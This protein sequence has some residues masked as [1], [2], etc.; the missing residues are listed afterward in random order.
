MS[1][2][3]YQ[4]YTLNNDA[5]ERDYLAV[6][7]GNQLEC[8]WICDTYI[9]EYTI[10]SNANVNTTIT[11]DSATDP[12][13]Q[14]TSDST[15]D[16]TSTTSTINTSTTSDHEATQ[17]SIQSNPYILSS[18]PSPVPIL[19][20]T[21]E[22]VRCIYLPEGCLVRIYYSWTR[23]IWAMSSDSCWN[24]RCQDDGPYSDLV[25]EFESRIKESFDSYTC[26]LDKYSVYFWH[27][28]YTNDDGTCTLNQDHSQFYNPCSLIG[29]RVF[30]P[31]TKQYNF[32]EYRCPIID[33]TW[34]GIYTYLSHDTT[35]LPTTYGVLTIEPMRFITTKHF[36]HIRT[37]RGEYNMLYRYLQLRPDEATLK[38]FIYYYASWIPEFD[39]VE[40]IITD[41]ITNMILINKCSNKSMCSQDIVTLL[42]II[43]SPILASIILGNQQVV[44]LPDCAF[45]YKS[46]IKLIHPTSMYNMVIQRLPTHLRDKYRLLSHYDF[47]EA[48]SDLYNVYINMESD[49]IPIN[50]LNP[51]ESRAI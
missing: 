22:T 39:V 14:P 47:V 23:N 6:Y 2:S 9:P 33:T 50:N 18:L 4:Q 10:E 32:I 38:Q 5:S 13:V 36:T 34:N 24:A 26:D 48:S 45:K 15:A 27:I 8:P 51:N 12:T 11:S 28:P 46:S 21:T 3:S 30:Q 31:G 41:L 44:Q 42:S 19:V 1:S 7:M 35:K 29:V 49:G 20:S 17:L 43:K 37:L 25:K 16:T 40:D